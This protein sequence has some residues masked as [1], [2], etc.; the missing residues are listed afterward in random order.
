MNLTYWDET[1]KLK[2]L[3]KIVT[4]IRDMYNECMD[5]TERKSLMTE[6]VVATSNIS[7]VMLSRWFPE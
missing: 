3:K 5:A 1:I 7:E 6:Y 2:R 4:T